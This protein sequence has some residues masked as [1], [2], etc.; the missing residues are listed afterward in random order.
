MTQ[1]YYGFLLVLGGIGGCGEGA[2]CMAGNGPGFRCVIY[3]LQIRKTFNSI[4][5]NRT[6][7][8]SRKSL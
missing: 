1:E 5:R 8:F 3:Y 6:L 2:G 7:S 4:K